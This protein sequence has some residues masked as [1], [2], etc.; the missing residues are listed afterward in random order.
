[1]HRI[2][3]AAETTMRLSG[4]V[5]AAGAAALALIG[6]A[7]FAS[8]EP[9][10][11]RVMT[12]QLPNGAVEHIRYRGNVPPQVILV[13]VTAVPASAAFQ[14]PFALLDQMSAMMDRQAEAML[15]AVS[16]MAAQPFSV[17]TTEAAF[18]RMSPGTGVCMRS[19]QVTYLGNGQQPHV[20]SQTT[21]DCGPSQG[22]TVPA[23][24][25]VPVTPKHDRRT[26]EVKAGTLY[27]DMVHQVADRRG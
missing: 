12:V 4:S 15:R 20:V 2:S 21:G 17:P 7:R 26:I 23:Q 10:D 8:A 9:A 19:I 5:L 27:Q 13:P 6:V 24:Q 18:G 3:T 1:M 11:T 22:A 25:P 16:A 14:S